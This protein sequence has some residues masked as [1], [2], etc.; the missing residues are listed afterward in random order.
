MMDI[1]TYPYRCINC[2]LTNKTPSDYATKTINSA[3][4]IATLEVENVSFDT[5]KMRGEGVGNIIPDKLKNRKKS[6]FAF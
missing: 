3:K 4:T 2:N 6:Y 1:V 5:S